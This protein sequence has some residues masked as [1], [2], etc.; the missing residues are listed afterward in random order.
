MASFISRP[1]KDEFNMADA[2]VRTDKGLQLKILGGIGIL[3]TLMVTAMLMFLETSTISYAL[4]LVLLSLLGTIT[5]LAID[6]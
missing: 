5:I 6:L 1:C 4:I 3:A 2:A